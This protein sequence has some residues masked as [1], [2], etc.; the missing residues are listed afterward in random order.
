MS[1]FA[2][3]AGRGSNTITITITI[4]IAVSHERRDADWRS[5]SWKWISYRKYTKEERDDNSGT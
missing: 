5:G 4:T 1:K 3:Q 2:A